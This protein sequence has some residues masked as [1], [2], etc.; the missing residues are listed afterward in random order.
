MNSKN[1]DT[2]AGTTLVL[3]WSSGF[4]GAV[5]GT[6]QAPFDTVLAWRTVV[7]AA[8][9]GV[10]ALAR[11]ERVSARDL[12]RLVVLGLLV[13]VVYLGGIFSATAAGVDA[14]T[15]AL[16]AALQPLVVAAVA[17]PLL[18]ERTTSRQRVGLV[19]AGLGVGLVVLG[20]L[21]SGH[22]PAWAY[23]LPVVAVAGLAAGTLLDRRWRPATS[24]PVSLGVQSGTAAL[25]FLAFAVSR[26]HLAPPTTPAFGGAVAWLVVLSSFGG[27]GSYLLVARRSG[28]TRAST[29]LYLTPP[30]SALAAWALFGQAPGPTAGPGLVVCAA[31]VA[32]ALGMRRRTGPQPA[33]RSSSCTVASGSGRVTST[34]SAMPRTPDDSTPTLHA[35][36]PAARSLPISANAGRSPRSSP[37]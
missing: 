14:G 6:D 34:A 23:A 37:R 20:D 25:V 22:A 7:S 13:Q 9:L 2:I 27:Y 29:L 28:A 31:G 18:G 32:L 15:C 21:G 12:R 4:V 10:W 8:V 5:M 26:G 30:T 35:G 11:R 3:C 1:V 16:V 33:S 24:V 19:V 17:D 36:T